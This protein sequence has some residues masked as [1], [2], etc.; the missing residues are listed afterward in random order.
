MALSISSK[1]VLVSLASLLYNLLCRNES[2]E[3]PLSRK[4]QEVMEEYRGFAGD[5]C[6]REGI[7]NGSIPAVDFFAPK[8]ID[9]AHGHYICIDGLYYASSFPHWRR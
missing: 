8:S 7:G 2:A 1:S 6:C 9:F 5:G 3:Q 4:V